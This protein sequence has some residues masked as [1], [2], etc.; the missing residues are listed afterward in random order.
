MFFGIAIAPQ[1]VLAGGA[2]IFT[3][4]LFQVLL[5][6]RVINLGKNHR[7]VHRWV[8]FTILG[9]AAVHGLAGFLFATGAR[10]G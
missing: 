9:I 6:L 1:V 8:A 7:V 4:L 5:G 10:I 3:L 2:T